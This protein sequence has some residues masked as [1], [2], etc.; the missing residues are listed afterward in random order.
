MSDCPQQGF[1]P[2]S[3]LSATKKSPSLGKKAADDVKSRSHNAPGVL[4]DPWLMS[5]ARAVPLRP[6]PSNQALQL[7][8][9][10]VPTLVLAPCQLHMSCFSLVG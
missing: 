6:K 8:L 4:L 1:W 10:A 7:L 5:S 2:G 3:E 9:K